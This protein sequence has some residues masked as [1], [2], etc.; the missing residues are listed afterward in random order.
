MGVGL[1]KVSIISCVHLL[2]NVRD[3]VGGVLLLVD[4]IHEAEEVHVVFDVGEQVVAG[5]ETLVRES[6]AVRVILAQHHRI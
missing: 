3:P 4:A 5:V 2:R 6:R 1:E